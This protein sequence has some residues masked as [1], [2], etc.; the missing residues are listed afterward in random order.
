MSLQSFFNPKAI[1]LVGASTNPEKIGR[2]I[3]DNILHGGF[4]ERFSY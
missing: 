1:A 2:Q 4:K 3:L